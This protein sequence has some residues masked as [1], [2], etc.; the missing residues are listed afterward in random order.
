MRVVRAG[1]VALFFALLTGVF[2]YPLSTDPGGRAL[3]LGADTRLFLWT[4]GWDLHAL[5]EHPFSLFNANIFYPEPNTLAYSEHV[6][7]SALLAAPVGAFTANPLASL[8]AVLLFSS[9]VSGLS[10]YFLARKLGMGTAGALAAGLIFAFAPP[11]FF[12]LGQLHLATVQWMP[13]C[14]AFLHAYAAGG[15]TRHL[16]A[17]SFFL[18]LQALSGGQTGLFLLLAAGGLLL[19]LGL[20]GE[21][22]PKSCLVRDLLLASVLLLAVNLSFVMPYFEVRREV[23]LERSLEEALPWSPNAASFLAAPTHL[24][25]ALVPA[26]T[27]RGARAYL[28]PGF[29]T[30]I[31]AAFSLARRPPGQSIPVAV[32]PCPPA[33]LVFRV[34][35]AAIPVTAAAALAVQAA[36]GLRWQIGGIQ[37][38]ARSGCRLIL[39]SAV[40]L[41]ARLA[42]TRS[43]P[44]SFRGAWQ[45]IVLGLRGAAERRVGLALGFY[46]V[47]AFLSVWASLGPRFGLYSALYRLLPGFDFVR[48]PSRLTI[49]TLLALAVLAGAGL[50][51]LLAQLPRRWRSL[52][53]AGGLALLAV[54][55][56]AFPLE[57]PPYS[58]P[59][60]GIDRWLSG[61][62]GRFAVV[63][64]PVADPRDAGRSAR[65]H[66]LYMLHG[67]A[68]WQRMVN[69]YSGFTPPS[70]DALFRKLVRFPDE[71]SLEALEALGVRYAIV[72]PDLY[73][74]AEWEDFTRRSEVQAERLK[75]VA[76]SREEAGRAYLLTR[77][78]SSP[79]AD[80]SDRER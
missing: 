62:P 17:A 79:Q 43:A 25:K 75:L 28:F 19:Y 32:V 71:E 44:W 13:P 63:E 6:L 78:E 60:P 37:I 74:K 34:W 80:R 10:A 69:G 65:L 14:L 11:R 70:H 46:V 7:G 16:L 73:T 18:T 55:F 29:L 21:L 36:G 66:S 22:R 26:E 20:V 56:A 49:L 52:A 5:R 57:A 8:N 38:S 3:D 51:R 48:V 64:L 30:L 12:R 67:M 24:Q 9:V 27:L 33:S 41:A 77:S 39:A 1:A 40:L 61:Q 45:R 76:S 2:C 54:E 4:L 50:D 53:A 31:L 15:A 42:L 23:G 47:L 72:H 35:D 58:I 59:A 68:H